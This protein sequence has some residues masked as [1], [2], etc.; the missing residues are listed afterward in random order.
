MVTIQREFR[1]PR[2]VEARVGPVGGIMAV[3][4]FPSAAAIVRI[5]FGMA[6][7]AVRRRKPKRLVLMAA[8]TTRLCVMPDERVARGVVI[9][10]DILPICGVMAAGAL[11]AEARFVD[12]VGFVT[13]EAV[14]RRLAIPFIQRMAVAAVDLGVFALEHEVG[15]LVIESRDVKADDVGVPALMVRVAACAAVAPGAPV[16][17]VIPDSCLDVCA[18]FLMACEAKYALPLPLE[19]LVTAVAIGLDIG[20]TLDDLARHD[21]SLDLGVRVLVG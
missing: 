6:P 12:V 18:H 1:I 13:A 9:E 11:G 14:G 7:V 16:T 4:A 20:V 10:L 15:Q 2:M 19:F 5:V 8:C 17:T 3:F 21:Q